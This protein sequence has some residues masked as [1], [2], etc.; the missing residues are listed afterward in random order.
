MAKSNEYY[1]LIERSSSRQEIAQYKCPCDCKCREAAIK[2]AVEK[3]EDGETKDMVAKIVLGV[4]GI[5]V[6]AFVIVLCVI[7]R[8]EAPFYGWRRYYW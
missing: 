8:S 1:N 6:L 2:S 7:I 4:I 3:I 5:S